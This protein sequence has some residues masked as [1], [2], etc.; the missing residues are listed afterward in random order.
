MKRDILLDHGPISMALQAERS[1]VFSLDAAQ[2][3][4]ARVK[5]A[6][7]ELVASRR[8]L[9]AAGKFI[10]YL[11]S[12]EVDGAPELLERMI[13]AVSGLREKRF[14]PLVAVAGILS[15]IAVEGMLSSGADYAL[16]NNGGDIAFRLPDSKEKLRVGIVSDLKE[17]IVTHTLAIPRSS[18]IGGLATSGFGGRSLTLGVAS[19]VTAL[20]ESSGLADAAATS[21]AN[22]CDCDDPSVDRCFAFEI[23]PATDIPGL[24]VTR[25]IGE[26]GEKSAK[27]A[28]RSGSRRAEELCA[29]GYI[30]GAVMFVGGFVSVRWSGVSCPFKIEFSAV[31]QREAPHSVGGVK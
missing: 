6:F 24:K 1:G 16:A 13:R 9:A 25:S 20:A 21:I 17:R 10:E 14:T 2:V 18:G 22:S 27:E 30:K 29:L 12:S 8:H 31:K 19:A 7:D 15:D 28:L 5:K 23:D 4:A 11:D 26:L 3:G